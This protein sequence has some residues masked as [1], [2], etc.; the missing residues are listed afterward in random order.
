MYPVNMTTYAQRRAELGLTQNEAALKAGVSL[1][2]WRRWEKAPESVGESTR[3]ACEAVLDEQGITQRSQA[4]TDAFAAAWAGSSR[5]TPRQATAVAWTLTYWADVDLADW[6]K[7]PAEP[8]H[9]LP[10]FS[11]LD[12]HIMMLVAE[13]RAWA[14]AV[15]RRCYSVAK[16]IS[17]GVLPFDRPGR[18]IDELVVILALHEAE[19]LLDDMPQLFENIPACVAV[20]DGDGDDDEGGFILDDSDWDTVMDDLFEDYR[21]DQTEV[22][23]R[24]NHPLMPLVLAE[25]P[26]FAWFDVKH[27]LPA[28]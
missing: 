3:I 20:D 18:L 13:N 23:Q 17:Q 26:P 27:D 28:A 6:I 19:G 2:T 8:L 10:P 16:E 15:Q 11:Q 7:N 12:L 22:L 4:E 25:L 1:A 21:W 5:L 9:Q 24:A 14:E